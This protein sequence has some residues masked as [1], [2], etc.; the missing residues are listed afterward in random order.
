MWQTGTISTYSSRLHALPTG[1]QELITGFIVEAKNYTGIVP[2]YQSINW[3]KEI[4]LSWYNFTHSGMA[5]GRW[6][7]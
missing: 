6:L 3:N 4:N 7:Y 1:T 2:R 5:T